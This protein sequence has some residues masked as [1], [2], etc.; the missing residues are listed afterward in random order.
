MVERNRKIGRE[1]YRF[2][3]LRDSIEEH[4]QAAFQQIHPPF[5]CVFTRGRTTWFPWR[6]GCP[7]TEQYEGV[8]NRY[9]VWICLYTRVRGFEFSRDCA[10]HHRSTRL[11]IGHLRNPCPRRNSA[12]FAQFTVKHWPQSIL[13]GGEDVVGGRAV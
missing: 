12:L 13:V 10:P 5:G 6:V 9:R 1:G 8:E 4:W 11:L 2:R 3:R 7:N